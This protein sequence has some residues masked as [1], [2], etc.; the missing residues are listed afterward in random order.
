MILLAMQG[1]TAF[2]IRPLR[3]ATLLG[4]IIAGFTSLYALYAVLMHV[5][6]DRTVTGWTSLIV[7]VLFLGGDADVSPG[8]HRRVRGQDVHG[9]KKK[10]RLYYSG[11]E[12]RSEQILL[13]AVPHFV[14]VPSVIS[15]IINFW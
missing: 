6:T 1:I 9:I 2:S 15:H 8:D 12:T 4:L 11:K 5:F 7:S 10:A 3:V 13:L 14:D